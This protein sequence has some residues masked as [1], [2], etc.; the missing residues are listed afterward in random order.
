LCAKMAFPA[1]F[2]ALGPGAV[3]LPCSLF[4]R[5]MLRGRRLASR[6][7][8]SGCLHFDTTDQVDGF[9]RV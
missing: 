9:V 2:A 4:D 1:R 7:D 3:V 8:N 5:R 6:I